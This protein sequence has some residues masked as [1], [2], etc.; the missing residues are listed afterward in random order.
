M[1]T[2]LAAYHA[3][4][5]CP[6]RNGPAGEQQLLEDGNGL[7]DA[8]EGEG[9]GLSL[10]DRVALW[11][12]AVSGHRCETF[13]NVLGLVGS[14]ICNH[15]DDDRKLW[16]ESVQRARTDGLLDEE[17]SRYLIWRIVVSDYERSSDPAFLELLDR[18]TAVTQT[19]G[20]EIEDLD[21]MTDP[22]TEYLDLHK[23]YTP[24]RRT[25]SAWRSSRRER[26]RWRRRCASGRRNSRRR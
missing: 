23:A 18:E 1:P 25:C 26:R 6:H 19:C 24:G 5:S 13:Y 8:Y 10:E 17:I 11:H 4:A 9:D 3:G 2:I 21:Q 7:Y 16:I 14:D 22:P 15:D 12:R 20:V